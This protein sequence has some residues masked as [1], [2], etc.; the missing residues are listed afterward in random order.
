[1][2]I[3]LYEC[4][5]FEVVKVDINYVGSTFNGQYNQFDH[6]ELPILFLEHQKDYQKITENFLNEQYNI[7]S[8]KIKPY[9]KTLDFN[10]W[11]EKIK[12]EL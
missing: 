12:K 3:S 11:I 4:K 8:K 2:I 10:Y 7:L 6:S 1:M 9:Y 5:R